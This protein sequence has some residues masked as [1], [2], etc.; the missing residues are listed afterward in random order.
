MM[1]MVETTT[2]GALVRATR[3]HVTP[4]NQLFYQ[5]TYPVLSLSLS[6]SLDP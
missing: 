3:E 5:S 6:L 1:V 2:N 4:P